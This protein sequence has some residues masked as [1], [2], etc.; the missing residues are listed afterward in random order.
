[1]DHGLL[2]EVRTAIR[3]GMAEYT[4][5]SSVAN[6]IIKRMADLHHDTVN[7]FLSGTLEGPLMF[8][9]KVNLNDMREV[10]SDPDLSGTDL[11]SMVP[12]Y[13]S[14][15][16]GFLYN[17]KDRKVGA[18]Y[19]AAKNEYGRTLS[20]SIT[21]FFNKKFLDELAPFKQMSPTQVYNL[22][23]RNFS[24]SLVHELRHAVDDHRFQ[25]IRSNK[26]EPVFHGLQPN[27]SA[28]SR[29]KARY[30][31][32][33]PSPDEDKAAWL[34]YHKG[35]LKM[36]HEIWARFAQVV[37]DVE[38]KT[39]TYDD[40]VRMPDGSMGITYKIVPLAV[41]LGGLSRM[42]GWKVIS[43]KQ[44]RRLVRALSNLWHEEEAWVKA[45]N[46]EVSKH[47]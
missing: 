24:S 38:F 25:D 11:A 7:Q 35:Y 36:P 4:A 47:R 29:F 10:L 41:V 40:Y 27:N 17:S 46:V 45:N 22:L 1:M 43:E 9:K 39:D 13:K 19:R 5:L 8:P 37:H 34:E 44:R 42:N 2:W 26:D 16:I 15:S 21:L 12:Q 33:K 23:S 3:E 6:A 31:S 30:A 28:A 14:F 32:K 18:D 20:V